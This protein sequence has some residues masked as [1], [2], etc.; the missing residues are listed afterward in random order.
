MLAM[1]NH[2]NCSCPSPHKTNVLRCMWNNMFCGDVIQKQKRKHLSASSAMPAT[3]SFRERNSLNFHHFKPIIFLKFYF[4]FCS[5]SP[6][7]IF[8]EGRRTK[9]WMGVVWSKKQD[10]LGKCSFAIVWFFFSFYGLH[11]KWKR[12]KIPYVTKILDFF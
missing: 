7:R 10:L 6:W 5:F 9:G 11:R 8:I 3:Q 12:K 4:L 1:L 2:S